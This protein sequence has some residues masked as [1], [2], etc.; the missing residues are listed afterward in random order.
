[1][2]DFVV[3]VFDFFGN[4]SMVLVVLEKCFGIGIVSFM[5]GICNFSLL[6]VFVM[7]GVVLGLV[8]VV[9]VINEVKVGVSV[10][11]QCEGQG[12]Q[13]VEWLVL[14]N[15]GSDFV[16]LCGSGDYVVFMF[17]VM[18]QLQCLQDVCFSIDGVV[19]IVFG[20][21]ICDVILGVIFNLNKIICSGDC[22]VFIVSNDNSGVKEVVNSFVN[23]FNVLIKVVVI[24]IC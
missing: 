10:I 12:D 14:S 17:S 20:N 13:V 2:G 21:Q 16:C 19:I 1:M 7:V 5:V 23:V 24:L 6:L 11:V 18:G 15:V 9:C 3:F 4:V 22:F 8:D